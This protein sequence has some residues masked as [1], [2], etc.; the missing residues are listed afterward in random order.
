MGKPIPY[1][2]DELS[3]LHKAVDDCAEAEEIFWIDD[4]ERWAREAKGKANE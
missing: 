1:T 4:L 3:R 2:K